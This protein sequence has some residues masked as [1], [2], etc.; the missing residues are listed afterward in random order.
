MRTFSDTDIQYL[1]D[2]YPHANTAEI[3]HKLGKRI[4]SI[5]RKASCLGLRKTEEFKRS[6]TNPKFLEEGK[7]RR[8]Q[9]GHT[10]A[11]KGKK[12]PKQVYDKVKHT[13]FKPGQ[14]PA[15]AKH[16]GEPHIHEKT[17]DGR[18]ERI[19]MIQPI[20]GKR[21]VYTS[22]LLKKHGIKRNGRVARLKDGYDYSKPPTIDDIELIDR[23]DNMRLN[24]YHRYPE[25]VSKLIQL[26]GVLTRQ[27]NKQK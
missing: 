5:H 20:G 10:P 14:I 2:H 4:D 16:F 25:E 13:M 17:I 8:F 1:I 6:M 21:Q 22:H 23:A 26:K 7:K 15:T 11:N 9:K 12:M 19:W 18:V 27:I 3:A 24:S